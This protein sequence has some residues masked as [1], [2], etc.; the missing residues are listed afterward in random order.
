M[1]GRVRTHMARQGYL[2]PSKAK[3]WEITSLGRQV[4]AGEV[5]EELLG[6]DT[7]GVGAAATMNHAETPTARRVRPWV[8]P[9]DAQEHLD[10]VASLN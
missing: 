2:V 9:G 5:K 7:E 10:R 8:T 1:I 3:L 6:K 4:A